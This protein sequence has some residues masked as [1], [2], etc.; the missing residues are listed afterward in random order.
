MY[1]L[2]IILNKTGILMHQLIKGHQDIIN[3]ILTKLPLG[4]QGDFPEKAEFISIVCE[5][6]GKFLCILQVAL[7]CLFVISMQ[8]Y[9]TII[10]FSIVDKHDN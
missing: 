7:N 6:I 1:I 3:E 9:D 8:F 2:I 4:T 10:F 5:K